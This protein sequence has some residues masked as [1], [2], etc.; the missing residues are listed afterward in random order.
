MT[1]DE[2][3]QA[4]RA[5]LPRERLGS[6]L[7][8]LR[9]MGYTLVGPTV[10]DGAIVYAE[11]AGVDDLPAGWTE[12][13]EAGTLPAATTRR[14][15]AVRLR[16]R[17]RTRG[18]S[19][20]SS[21]GSACGKRAAG[22]TGFTVDAGDRRAAASGAHRRALLR[23]AR[24]RGPGSDLPGR[25]APST[26]TTRAPAAAPFVVAVNCGQAGGTCFCVSM[27]T[28][29]RATAGFDLALTEL[30]DGAHRFVVE[31]GSE[32]GAAVLGAPRR[33]SR[34]PTPTGGRPRRSSSAPR[35]RWAARSTPPTSRSSSYR[36]LEHPRW[37]DVATRCLAC[38]NCTLV[39]PTCFCTTVEDTTDLTGDHAER[40][41]TLGLVLHARPLL[42]PRRQRADQ[43]PG[44]AT[45][46]G[47]R[48]SSRPGST[49][50]ARRAASAAAA[51]SPGA[52]SAS[53]SPRRSRAIRAGD[54]DGR[55]SQGAPMETLEPILAAHPFFQG[56]APEHLRA[57][58]RL[59]QQRALRRRRVPLPRRA[60]RRISSTSSAQGTVALEVRR[61]GPTG[62]S[63]CR[64]SGRATILGLVVARSPVPLAVRRARRRA[65]A[66]HRPRRQVPARQVRGRPRPRLRRSLKRYL[67]H[68]LGAPAGGAAPAPRRLRRPHGPCAMIAAHPDPM[69]PHPVSGAPCHRG[70]RT[71]PSPSSWRRRRR[72]RASP[73][74]VQHALR[75][76]RRRGADLG[77]RRPGAGRRARAHHPR[78]RHGDP[79]HAASAPRRDARRARSVRHAAGRST[80][81]PG[82]TSCSSPAA[83]GSRRCGRCSTRSRRTAADFGRVALLYGARSPEDLLYRGE[84]ERWRSASR[85]HGRG[86]R[87][88]RRRAAGRATSAS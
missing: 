1:G 64:R 54:T 21:R 72:W 67:A 48:T 11:I 36:N 40:W 57:A 33:A 83:S 3:P 5:I 60:R 4:A 50:S 34:P 18:S 69:L 10:R 87:R 76:R 56:L 53:T 78:G 30:L 26:R 16:G 41:R 24:H 38:A 9:S 14:P 82:A 44:R 85:H 51:A 63:S 81:A 73:G 42:H 7:D 28:G 49:S 46:S 71:T 77:Q 79:G 32:R 25:R 20:S 29:P 43:R 13:Q 47:S 39:C 45:G 66:R 15:G 88:P 23:S 55:T 8:V 62:A 65:D 2:S 22:R 86:H 74:T 84:L 58:G 31:V 70:D 17:A 80:R 61:P 52:R 59:R 75:L 6:L 12:E 68:P 27:G 35:P 19:S 37:D